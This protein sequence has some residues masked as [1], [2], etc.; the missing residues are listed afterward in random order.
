LETQARK[1][2]DF[3]ESNIKSNS[4]EDSEEKNFRGGLELPRDDRNAI[5]MLA[6]TWIDE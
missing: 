2:L 3:H 4:T 5:R 6:K 1:G